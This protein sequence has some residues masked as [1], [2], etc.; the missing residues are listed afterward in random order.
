MDDLWDK[1]WR[2]LR[3]G[4]RNQSACIEHPSYPAVRT[5]V[6]R[7]VNDIIEVS[8]DRTVVCSHQTERVDAIEADRFRTWWDHLVRHGHASL[9]PG[10][11]DNPHPLAFTRSWRHLGSLPSKPHPLGA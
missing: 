3:D 11:G 8:E 9:V 2:E 4:M 7:I 6:K 1:V 10:A 5:L